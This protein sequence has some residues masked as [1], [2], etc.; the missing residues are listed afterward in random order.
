[1]SCK[2]MTNDRILEEVLAKTK[3]PATEVTGLII[4]YLY[5]S[6]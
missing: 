6:I 2:G 5:C 1:M 4:K 3:K